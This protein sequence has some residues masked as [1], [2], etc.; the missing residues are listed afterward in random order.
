MSDKYRIGVIIDGVTYESKVLSAKNK[1]VDAMLV[2]ITSNP[3][4]LQYLSFEDK[5][6]RV[7]IWRAKALDR[8]TIYIEEVKPKKKVVKK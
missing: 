3:Q 7:Y 2:E 5:T 8:S 6:G 4:D 1:D